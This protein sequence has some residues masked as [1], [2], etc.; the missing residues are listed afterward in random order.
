MIDKLYEKVYKIAL[1]FQEV[2]EELNYGY[3]DNDAVDLVDFKEIYSLDINTLENIIKYYYDNPIPYEEWNDTQSNEFS[4]DLLK[5]SEK[6]LKEE[7]EKL[8]NSKIIQEIQKI[9]YE[10]SKNE[11]CKTNNIKWLKDNIKKYPEQYEIYL[12]SKSD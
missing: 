1:I 4:L 2:Q 6:D 11:S 8:V 10:I 7:I 12:K 9:E 5:F 3:L